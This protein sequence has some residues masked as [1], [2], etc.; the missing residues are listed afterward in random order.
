[1]PCTPNPAGWRGSLRIRV[2]LVDDNGF[3]VVGA[4]CRGE[5]AR[6]SLPL[7]IVRR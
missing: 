7:P 5:E 3:V 1:M 6:E 4:T 2:L